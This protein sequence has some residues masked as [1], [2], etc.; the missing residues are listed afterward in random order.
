MRIDGRIW[1]EAIEWPPRPS[2][3]SLAN[4]AALD[5]GVTL[6]ASVKNLADATFIASR[7][8][9]GIKPGAPRMVTVGVRVTR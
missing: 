2:C 5:R 3:I 4:G 6:L 8:P 1:L 7:R 9:E